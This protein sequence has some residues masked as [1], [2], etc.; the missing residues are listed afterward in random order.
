[1]DSI[2]FGPDLA[3]GIPVLDQ[4]HR[5][6]FDML[7]AMEELRPAFDA[8]C[9]ELTTEFIEHLR[10][11]NSLMERIG[12]PAAQAHR[13]AHGHL[14]EKA[15]RVLR[16]LKD[17]EEARAREIIRSLPDWLEAHINTMDLALAVAV[18]R[19]E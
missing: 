2:V 17:D 1:M 4:S 15:A 6:V 5:I 3:L 16:L 8:A 19:L 13:I 9:R 10:E 14:L 18:S 12:Y 7:D 11:E